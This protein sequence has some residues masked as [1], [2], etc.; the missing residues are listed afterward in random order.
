MGPF[1]GRLNHDESIKWVLGEILR[2]DN[3]VGRCLWREVLGSF[4]TFIAIILEA[5]ELSTTTT[6]LQLLLASTDL[7]NYGSWHLLKEKSCMLS[8]QEGLC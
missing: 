6:R 4:L 3:E 1:W 2:P 8:G 5:M 7:R